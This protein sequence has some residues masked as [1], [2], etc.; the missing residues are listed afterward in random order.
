M[1][2]LSQTTPCPGGGLTQLGPANPEGL[3]DVQPDGRHF[4]QRTAPAT[5]SVC[6]TRVFHNFPS[7]RS[8]YSTMEVYTDL[9]KEYLR[10]RAESCRQEAA[11]LRKPV[12]SR[13]ERSH[14]VRRAAEL[15]AIASCLD[16]TMDV[17]SLD[18]ILLAELVEEIRE[19]ARDLEESNDAGPARDEACADLASTAQAIDSVYG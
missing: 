14:N 4:G 18:P 7:G 10:R 19:A 17:A 1:E 3:G 12:G 9:A 15:D 5:F 16:R 6:T 2:L 8:Y 11:G 13:Q